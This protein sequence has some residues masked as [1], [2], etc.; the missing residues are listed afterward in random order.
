[1]WSWIS[2]LFR[3]DGWFAD[4]LARCTAE[5]KGRHDFG[6]AFTAEIVRVARAQ[7]GK[8]EVGGN[9]RGPFIRL[10]GGKQGQSWCAWLASWIIVTAATNLGMAPPVKPT[11]G[12]R[13]LF[14][15]CCKAG[16]RLKPG[17]L[18]Q[19]GD[20][21]C[22]FRGPRRLWRLTWKRHAAIVVEGGE[23]FR[24]IEGNVGR[25][26]AEVDYFDHH[27]D[28]PRIDGIARLG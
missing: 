21:V 13:R 23:T 7:V 11:G 4:A 1:M 3:R 6:R 17:E 12:A 2:G 10:I 20:I 19:P 15:R 28:D 22:F 25:P 26:P 16:R 5:W 9:N 14:R 8:G 27:I 18:P 24:T